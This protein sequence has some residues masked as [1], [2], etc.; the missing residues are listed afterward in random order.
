MNSFPYF[1]IDSIQL[2]DLV[3]VY[4][5]GPVLKK[6]LGWIPERNPFDRIF[7][8]LILQNQSNCFHCPFQMTPIMSLMNTFLIS[9]KTGKAKC[10]SQ[11]KRALVEA[12]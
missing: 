7:L 12:R 8:S 3:L 10:L 11:G 4:I 9:V 2:E 1:Q 6:F 5:L